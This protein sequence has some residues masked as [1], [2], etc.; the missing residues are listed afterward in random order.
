MAADLDGDGDQDVLAS[1]FLPQVQLPLPKGGMRVDS[2]IWFERRADA[3]IPWSVGIDLPRHT[4]MTVVDLNGDGRLD[5]V[6]GINTAWDVNARQEGP[7]LAMWFNEGPREPI[8]PAL[9]GRFA[10]FRSEGE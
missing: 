2:L 8:S 6:A 10:P 4:G 7:S 3:W 9:R 1:G 5:V